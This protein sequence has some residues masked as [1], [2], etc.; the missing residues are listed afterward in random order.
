MTLDCPERV[1]RE[2]S[3]LVIEEIWAGF[4]QSN[5]VKVGLGLTWLMMMVRNIRDDPMVAT[6]PYD[7]EWGTAV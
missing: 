3:S 6:V 1:R 2:Q 5:A 7:G 4:L